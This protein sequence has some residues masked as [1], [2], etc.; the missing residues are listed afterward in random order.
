MASRKPLAGSSSTLAKNYNPPNRITPLSNKLEPNPITSTGLNKAIV[1][2]SNLERDQTGRSVE[3]FSDTDVCP[4]CNSDRYLNPDLRLLVSRCYHKMCES[5]IDRIFSLGPEPCPICGQIL[6]KSNFAPQT[7]E[8]LKV[9][10]EV[11]IRKRITK[12]FNKRPEDFASLTDYNNYLEEVED[13]T[14]NLINDVDVAETEAKIK[15]FKQENQDLIAQNVVHEARQ[16]ELIKRKEEAIKREREERKAELIR[17]E[18]EAR[19]EERALK[20]ETINSLATS[21]VSAEKL[22]ARQ[23]ILAQKKSAARA[24]ASDIATKSTLSMPSLHGLL[25]STTNQTD[26]VQRP[27]IELELNKWNNYS[28]LFE[29]Q[30]FEDAYRPGYVDEQSISLVMNDNGLAFVGGFNLEDVW[31]RQIRSS[32]MGLF[33]PKPEEGSINQLI[34]DDAMA[35]DLV[36][37]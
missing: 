36:T 30:R 18:E 26:E 11:I 4:V 21:D 12:F 37:S 10:K 7:F 8:N 20:D 34:S 15:K 6:R 28:N 9:E 24:L 14:F 31:E 5:C 3:F 13:I 27:D 22:I 29:L 23:R 16:A 32:L 1:G 2:P 25:D 35:I 33:V 17:L 19:K